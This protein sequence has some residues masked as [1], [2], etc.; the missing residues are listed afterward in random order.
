MQA[1][2]DRGRGIIVL[3]RE[4]SDA[5]LSSTLSQMIAS[6]KGAADTPATAPKGNKRDSSQELR[7]YG[8]GAQILSD[9]GIRRMILL[10]NTQ[11]HV[12]SLDGYDLEITGWQGLDL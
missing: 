10:S 5:S 4:S 12:I 2:S 1:I 6:G 3:L 7:E 9:L 8:V 11:S